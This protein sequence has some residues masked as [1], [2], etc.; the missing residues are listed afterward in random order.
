MRP[1]HEMPQ[2]DLSSAEGADECAVASGRALTA[3]AQSGSPSTGATRA[4]RQSRSGRFCLATMA[5]AEAQQHAADGAAEQGAGACVGSNPL[6]QNS[7]AHGDMSPEWRPTPHGRLCSAG[8][9]AGNAEAVV[10]APV[11]AVPA[12]IK[13]GTAKCAA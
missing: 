8:I 5:D 4:P 3:S 13:H 11:A 9:A 6:R 7:P 2:I 12:V 10:Q 1:L